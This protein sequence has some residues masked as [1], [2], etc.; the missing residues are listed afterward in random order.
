MIVCHERRI[1]FVKTKKVGGTSFEIALSK[2]CGPDCI[3]TPITP[4]DEEMRIRLGFRGAQNYNPYQNGE[5]AY[6][7]H[8]TAPQVRNVVHELIW[9]DYKKITIVRNPFEVLVSKYFWRRERIT[10]KEFVVNL[11]DEINENE[12]IAPISGD[13]I[14]DVYLKYEDMCADL[15][16]YN[17]Q[18]LADGM[19]QIRAKGHTR[20]EQANV[21]SMFKGFPELVDLV[22]HRC[23]ETIQR[24]NYENPK[25]Y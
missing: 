17:L 3:I 18:Y 23:K 22:S 6:Y 12:V 25:F 16:R 15:I 4:K 5:S 21:G 9:N 1:I 11:G 8:M 14:L 7:N 24:F 2:F 13:N 10:F 20:P 19:A